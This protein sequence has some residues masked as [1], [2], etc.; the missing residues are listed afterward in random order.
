[1]ECVV[2]CTNV[3]LCGITDIPHDIAEIYEG[4]CVNCDMCFMRNFT[5]SE[6]VVGG[7][8]CPICLVE[9][10]LFLTY[11]CGHRVCASCFSPYNIVGFQAPEPQD[12]GCPAFAPEA[13]EDEM[14]SVEEKWKL[15]FPTQ[16]HLYNT[17]SASYESDRC[18]LF[19][20]KK[21]LIKKC[22]MCRAEG[23][24]MGHDGWRRQKYGN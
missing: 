12:F 11:P 1:M 9:Q 20:D 24:P 6:A 13:D 19:D 7:E 18:E 21:E 2:S 23:I 5:F 8:S 3:P 10:V 4:R 14:E 22:P 17:T 16:Y 15:A